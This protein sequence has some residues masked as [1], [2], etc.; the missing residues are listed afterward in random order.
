[1]TSDSPVRVCPQC[2]RSILAEAE[3]CPR[4][5]ARNNRPGRSAFAVLLDWLVTAFV[6]VLVLFFGLAG[7]C[8]LL[9]GTGRG[10]GGIQSLA[11]GI[12]LLLVALALIQY[13]RRRRTKVRG[14]S[15]PAPPT[16]D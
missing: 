7:A 1:M 8:F 3:F 5:G 6:L 9:L 12:G 15:P 10:P 13:L 4:C 11:V 14:S 2:G 16:G